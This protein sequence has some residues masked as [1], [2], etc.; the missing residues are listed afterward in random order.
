MDRFYKIKEY[1]SG[2]NIALI[3]FCAYL[4]KILIFKDA[5]YEDGFIMFFLSG[6]YAYKMHLTSKQPIPINMQVIAEMDKLKT[7]VEGLKMEKTLNRKPA[8]YF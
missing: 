5:S 6:L 2:T 7:T 4:L 8:K 1:L 3:S